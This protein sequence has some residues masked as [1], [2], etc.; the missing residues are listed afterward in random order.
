MP[1]DNKHNKKIFINFSNHPS[2]NWS[3]EQYSEAIK[4]GEI[5]DI[6]FP[7][8]DPELDSDG[9]IQ[10]AYEYAE[11]I[12]KYKPAAV[13]CQGEMT[14]SFKVVEMLKSKGILV[15]AACSAKEAY[16]ETQSDGS[17]VKTHRFRF[18]RFRSY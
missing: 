12:M 5:I 10:L 13:M 6:S 7:D 1:G 8:V 2:A 4:Y 16:Y 15:L 18:V 9:I 3:K 14:L 11:K 17:V